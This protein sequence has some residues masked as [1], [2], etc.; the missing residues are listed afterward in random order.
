MPYKLMLQIDAT[1]TPP[2][3]QA[4]W[5]RDNRPIGEP[6][7][8]Q[9]QAARA[10]AD[11]SRRFLVLFEQDGRPLVDPESLRAIGR[12]L[13]ATWFAPA[14]SA[15]AAD[16]DGPG[17][18]DLLIQSADRRVLNLPW[19][20]VELAPDLPVGCDAAWS[21]RR[22][23]LKKAAPADSP[24]RPGPLRIA[25]LAAAPID[26]AQLD[27]EREED[28][29]LSATARLPGVAVQFAELG[30]FEELADLVAECRPHV[31]HLSG[32]GR[33][34]AEGQATFAFEDERGQTDSRA[35]AEIVSQ[36]F[37]GSSVQCV[38]FNGC[39]TSQADA[40]G[41]CQSLVAAGVPLAVGWSANV[42]DD[43]ATEFTAEFYRR[44][45]RGEPVAAAAAHARELIRGKGRTGLL[46]DASFALLQ[47]YS[48]AA[49]GAIFD[50][51]AVP[52]PYAGPRTEYVLLG[53]GIKGLREG[54]VGRRRERQQLVPALRYGDTTFA[55]ITGIGGAGKSTL[56]TRA[57]NLLASAGFRIV[58]IRVEE[59]KG[60]LGS[61]QSTLTRLI[62]ELDDAFIQV[63]RHDLRRQ[64]TDANL[65][66]SQRLRL[67]VKGL[68][69]LKLVIVIDNFEDVL[70]LGTRRIVEPDLAQVYRLLAAG[71]TR[72]SRVIITCRYLPN[73]LPKDVPTVLHLPL[74]DL[75]EPNFLKFLRRDE[76]VDRRIGRGELP[77][78]LIR[79]LYQK[80]GGTPGFLENV[81]RVLRTADPDDLIEDLEGGTPGRLSEA[82]ESYYER[83]IATRLYGA[84]SAEARNI[85]SRLAISDLPLPMDGVMRIA[86][87]DETLVGSSLEAGFAFGLLQRFDE[88]DLPSLYHPPG[89]LRPW[90]SDPERLPEADASIVHERLAAFW[91]SSF[92]ANREVELRVPVEVELWICRAHAK[93][94][95]DPAT[96]QWATIWL[97]RL[98]ERRTEWIAARELL[99]QIPEPE[100]DTDCLMVLAGV[101]FL[102]GEWKAARIH[103]EDAHQR[104]PN[105]SL[106]EALAL[107][108]LATIDLNEGDYPA[109]EEK[110]ANALQIRQGLGDLAGEAAS[111]HQLAA[112][113]LNRS[114]YEAAQM[115]L[116][117][118]LEIQRAL[119]DRSGEAVTLHELAAIDLDEGEYVKA[120]ERS[121]KALQM[122]Q[123]IG[124]R[125]GEA[126]A[127]HQLA[128]IDLREDRNTTARERFQKALKISQELGDRMGEAAALHGLA[129]IDLR[130]G[131]KLAAREEFEKSLEI[132]EDLGNQAGEAA[133][134]HQLATLDLDEGEYVKARERFEKALGINLV[135]GN[136]S[137]EAATLHNLATIDFKEGRNE[138]AWEKSIRSLQIKQEIGDRAGEA[139]TFSLIGLIIHKMGRIHLGARLKAIGF[140]IANAIGHGDANRILISLT[141]LCS[142]L[143]YDQAQFDAMMAEAVEAYQA[144][145][146]RALIEQAFA[147]DQ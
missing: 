59:G 67:A 49:A 126:A 107:H 28:A 54:F 29:M 18:R 34:A 57:A 113:D 131:A 48:S 117:S 37:R 15:V 111:L 133:T 23:P 81:R 71:L 62:G 47:V 2:G 35:A 17:P 40:A 63:E 13:F 74:P 119:G 136:R 130:E 95:E 143:R 139:A 146:G 145:R 87:A 100:R 50:S 106:R 43:R 36:V 135:R 4:R 42:A 61:G 72:G 103:F 11:L 41:L 75:D 60:P 144:D 125:M 20:L 86:E 89:L 30:S 97:S 141:A 102:L 12:G 92:E 122:Q 115:K 137:G 9:D 101:E 77:M 10:I 16:G 116:V 55:L 91:R 45:V 108:Q 80:L 46:Q 66:L 64:L 69:E 52:E 25:F 114:D 76:D 56:A 98:L 90:L 24:L 124:N 70:E 104:M 121:E 7:T 19:E 82:R 65:P 105:G 128:S 84:M 127:F 8:V 33:M 38:F 112:I 140:N 142:Q 14:W 83:I 138:L 93:C 147:E 51:K 88:P 44:L 134:L 79:D 5:F 132:N 31:V 22:S 94:S 85:V 96:F 39:Q 68:N 118:V 99:E 109:A 123:E 32:H 129:S 26:Q 1:E 120:R 27:Y 3:W 110:F 6:I 53:D 78:T 58:P 21:L 73:E